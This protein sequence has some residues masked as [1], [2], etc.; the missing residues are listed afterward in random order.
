M[1][2]EAVWPRSS[3]SPSGHDIRRNM[4][5]RVPG[6]L[7]DRTEA[8]GSTSCWDRSW[9]LGGCGGSC[10]I[11]LAH[12]TTR[13]SAARTRRRPR[14]RVRR[15]RRL[16]LLERGRQGRARGGQ[17]DLER[18]GR[19]GA[20]GI[21]LENAPA[22]VGDRVELTLRR[23]DARPT[24]PASCPRWTGSSTSAAASPTSRVGSSR[25]ATTSSSAWAAPTS[26]SASQT[27]ARINQGAARSGK[28]DGLAAIG[29]DPLA[30]IKDVRGRGKATVGGTETTRYTGS[31]D[32]D[33]ALDQVES[34]LRRLPR[35]GTG[36]RQ[37]PQLELTPE[38]R[39]QV[40]RTFQAPALRG[41]RGRRRHDPPDRADHPVR[42]A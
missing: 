20:A 42:D 29:L 3:R 34:F 24:G 38:R 15:Q 26:S 17:A 22:E 14:G 27:I 1:Y 11:V 5:G 16:E 19:R 7:R 33:R 37:V 40:K 25:P 18:D 2:S 35:Q 39:D 30:A 8:G 41:R 21:N 9:D 12:E 31:I 4:A 10:A 28:A 23:P 6:G 36:G 32:V 13:P